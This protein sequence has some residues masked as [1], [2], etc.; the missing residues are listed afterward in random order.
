MAGWLQ[1]RRFVEGPS[2]KNQ[3][4]SQWH[5][6]GAQGKSTSERRSLQRHN[7]W[8]TSA[9][10]PP[11]QA[12]LNCRHQWVN[13]LGNTVSP[14]SNHCSRSLSPLK[15]MT[16]STPFHVFHPM[17]QIKWYLIIVL[18]SLF[19]SVETLSTFKNCV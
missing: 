11:P 10:A 1:G 12:T 2:G 13:P 8:L 6:Y 14:W 19:W 18:I 17:L 3:H 4:I 7:Q 15:L 9:W 16:N 5:G